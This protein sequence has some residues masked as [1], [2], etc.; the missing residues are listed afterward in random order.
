MIHTILLQLIPP[1]HPALS[2]VATEVTTEDYHI[3]MSVKDELAKLMRERNGCGIAAPQ[4]GISKR[5]FIFQNGLAINPKIEH[6]G[7]DKEIDREGCLTYG[8]KTVLRERWRIIEVSYSN[9][10]GERVHETLRGRK[11][12]C[13]QHEMDHLNGITLFNQ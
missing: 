13:F 11:A 10:K 7:R 6:R 3:V 2:T 9:D 1:D 5:F 12:R 8:T 4:V